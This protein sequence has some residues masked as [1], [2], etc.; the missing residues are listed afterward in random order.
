[1][2]VPAAAAP[3]T[4][5][6]AS[7]IDART[8]DAL[9]GRAL[10]GI[11]LAASLAPLGS[12]MIAV[13]LPSIGA[14]LH[15]PSAQ[16][17]QWLATSYLIVSMAFQTSGGKL[18]D[19]IGHRRNL[20]IGMVIYAAGGVLGFAVADLP[21]LVVARIAMA[22]GS[23]L[24]LPSALAQIRVRMDP[25]RRGRAFGYFG[26]AMGVAAALGPLLGGEL[27]QRF[28][29]RALFIAPLPQ[30][31]LAAVLVRAMPVDNAATAG[32]ARGGFDFVGSGLLALGTGLGAAGLGSHGPQAPVLVAVGLAALVGFVVWERRASDPIVD[33]R[34][35]GKPV[36][37]AGGAVI[38]LTNLAM[39]A[40]LFQLPIYFQRVHPGAAA[41]LGRTLMAMMVAMVVCSPIGA[42][43]ADRIGP[44]AT[45]TTGVLLALVA[46]SRF[47]ALT[48]M[49]M[50]R[51]AVVGLVLLGAG[52]GL[53]GAPSQVSAMNVVEPEEAGAAAGVFATLRYV[54][55][56]LGIAILGFL[57]G[58]EAREADIS[59]HLLSL[60]FYAGALLLALVA[61][62]FLPGHGPATRRADSAA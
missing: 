46:V 34:L 2:D 60:P 27:V 18:G 17:T 9:P 52:I 5:T 29:W 26:A 15:L 51:D 16:L 53:V 14:D 30:L 62:R 12:T 50:P 7:A 43:L 8:S 44:R 25:E 57:L 28:G 21:A 38:A 1:M 49:R 35:F 55:G 11:L 56:V 61:A 54:G 13:A 23:A 6:P 45:V 20:N 19:R 31:A 41:E 33:L 47:T 42:R 22:A 39:Y 48:S 37:T 24:M 32:D 10:F 58:A 40:L 36:F 4:G 59:R 3:A